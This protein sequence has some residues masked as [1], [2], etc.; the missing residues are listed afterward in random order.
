[1][2]VQFVHVGDV[3]YT[4]ETQIEHVVHPSPAQPHH[5]TDVRNEHVV[6]WLRHADLFSSIE[7]SSHKTTERIVQLPDVLRV[8][9]LVTIAGHSVAM[10][11]W[12][13]L[14]VT[15]DVV[16]I[17]CVC[18]CVCVRACV[19]VCASVRACMRACVC[20]HAG[21]TVYGRAVGLVCVGTHIVSYNDCENAVN[22]R[23]T[24]VAIPVSYSGA[25]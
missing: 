8:D 6:A 22:S 9:G 25:K 11:F 17:V 21:Y 20:V 19:R 24:D 13:P 5:V 14:A 4:E 18:V 16:Y 15:C 7:E 23:P 2:D 12:Y 1:M 3:Q 10:G